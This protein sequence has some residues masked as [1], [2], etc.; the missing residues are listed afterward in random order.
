[1]VK[2]KCGQ[3]SKAIHFTK[4]ELATKPFTDD[5]RNFNVPNPKP[6]VSKTQPSDLPT[7]L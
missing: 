4:S 6:I 2:R 7:S 5:E 1:M 3:N